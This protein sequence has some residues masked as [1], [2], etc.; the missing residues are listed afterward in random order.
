MKCI[1]C[2]NKNTKLIFSKFPGYIE[3]TYYK[4][5]QCD[6]CNSQF[7]N[8]NNI[9]LNIYDKIYSN[10]NFPGYDRYL[11]FAK[12]IKLKKDPLHYLASQEEIYFACEFF[13]KNKPKQKILEIGCGYGYLTYALNK[14]GHNTTGID[15]SKKA[16]QFAKKISEKNIFQLQLKII[17]ILK[18]TI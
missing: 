17:T 6:S 11:E 15:I 8:T 13:L 2:N 18:N 5:Y 12:K 10:I 4:I 1:I 14:E 9:N 3:N 7:I 16:I